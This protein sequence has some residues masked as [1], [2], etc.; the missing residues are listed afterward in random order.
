MENEELCLGLLSCSQDV[1]DYVLMELAPERRQ[2]VQD[3]MTMM[4]GISSNRTSSA[5]FEL[6]KRF[7]EVMV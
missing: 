3:Q 2:L 5:R 6:V 1:R 4:N 7:R